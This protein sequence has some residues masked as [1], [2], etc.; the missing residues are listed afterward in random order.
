MTTAHVMKLA[1]PQFAPGPVDGAALTAAFA[2]FYQY[3]LARMDLRYPGNDFGGLGNNR[4]CPDIDRNRCSRISA[5]RL[6]DDA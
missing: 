5:D 2:T 4:T 1:P 6:P 3:V